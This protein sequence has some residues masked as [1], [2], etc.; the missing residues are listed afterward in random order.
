MLFAFGKTHGSF[1]FSHG[2][3][4][5]WKGMPN[6][7]VPTLRNEPLFRTLSFGEGGAYFWKEM[8]KADSAGAYCG[9]WTEGTK[10]VFE[11]ENLILFF[12]PGTHEHPRVTVSAATAINYPLVKA[13]YDT[14][15]GINWVAFGPDG[16]FVIDTTNK[17]IASDPTMSR[18]YIRNGV[19]ARVPMRCAS[20]GPEGVWVVV[21][22]DGEIRSKGLPMNVSLALLKK[23]VRK[24]ELSPVSSIY[25]FIEYTDGST[26]W[27]LP[28]E[29]QPQ[30]RNIERL[31]L[32]LG[33]LVNMVRQKIVFAFGPERELYCITNQGRTAW[34][35]CSI[36][37]SQ[38]LREPGSPI[39][40]SMGEGGAFFWKKGLSYLVSTATEMAYPEV[41]KI[42]KRDEPIN[43]VVF[44]PEGY[45]IVDTPQRI[46]ASR[47]DEVLRVYSQSKK[48][49]PIRCASFGWGGSW[50]II[51]DDGTVRSHRLKPNVRKAMLQGS[52]RHVALS[53]VDPTQFY[54]EYMDQTSDWSLPISWHP[55]VS[56]IEGKL[57]KPASK[58]ERLEKLAVNSPEY[59]GAE[60]QF[61]MS[62]R[63]VEKKRPPIR[64]IYKIVLTGEIWESYVQ[65]RWVAENISVYFSSVDAEIRD[66]SLIRTKVGNEQQLFHCT[67]RKCTI[68]D[69]GINT[70]LCSIEGCAL[71]AIMRTSYC[72]AK[73]RASGMFGVGIYTS[74][75][76]S[77]AAG[78]ARNYSP[79]PY[80]A[81]LLNKVAVGRSYFTGVADNGRRGPPPGYNSVCGLP[82]DALKHDETIVYD[83][84]AIRP[85]YL[86][87]YEDR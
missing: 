27:C 81:M 45:Y 11:K 33:V 50:V 86:I 15:E 80:K 14:D 67:S 29:W 53:W 70:E 57:P 21:E 51:E 87:I 75:T 55:T 39:A 10:D 12:T 71:C 25:Y 6:T 40:V 26:D 5:Y 65:Y 49:V 1:Y 72:V 8:G 41:W 24:I 79:S 34:R 74:S 78:Y 69:S 22:D 35:G 32:V 60:Y 2:S 19:A 30:V 62:W 85:Q 54:V 16:A 73:A 84:D 17:L 37:L 31:N 83:D 44:G 48:Q 4:N 28:V 59:N 42:W 38:L 56:D 46:Y 47:Q 13:I 9:A 7:L 61:T 36:A 64:H 58:V 68:G 23:E 18:T 3:E 82:G 63:H 20:F 76:S 52:V 43:W 77:K 66:F